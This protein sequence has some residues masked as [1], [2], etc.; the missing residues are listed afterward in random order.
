MTVVTYRAERCK[1]HRN[2]TSGQ[3][4]GDHLFRI[5][6]AGGA[7]EIHARTPAF[8]VVPLI[9]VGTGWI[10]DRQRK[11]LA[12]GTIIPIVSIREFQNRTVRGIVEL[13]LFSA[14]G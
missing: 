9:P 7:V 3:R 14:I 10:F 5:V 1:K 11:A 12:V 8:L 6:P 2:L 13:D 4:I